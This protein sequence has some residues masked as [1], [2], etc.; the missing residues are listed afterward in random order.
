MN[1]IESIKKR[2][3]EKSE[4]ECTGILEKAK[5]EADSIIE[6][7]K[8]DSAAQVEAIIVKATKKAEQNLH[9]AETAAHLS[10]KR[11]VL[12][13]KRQVI[14]SV[15]KAA[16]DKLCNLDAA[17]Y[18]KVLF[19]LIEK[20]NTNENDILRISNNTCIKLGNNVGDELNAALK[21]MGKPTVR[22]GEPTDE[23]VGGFIL[24]SKVSRQICSY[25]GLIESKREELESKVA[26]IL[27]GE[28]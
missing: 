16:I 4:A 20:C 18:K 21:A 19:A 10:V 11:D 14:S 22:I 17:E 23:F 15:F 25:E 26:D 28:N 2:I 27:F 24:E 8:A 13:A 1:G 9:V 3:N 5:K 7:Q 12:I 6:K